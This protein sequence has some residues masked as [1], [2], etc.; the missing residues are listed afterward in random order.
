MAIISSSLVVGH[1]QADGRRYV[2]ETHID[3]LGIEHRFEYGPVGAEVDCDAVM[4]ARVVELAETLRAAEFA[5]IEAELLAGRN[6]FPADAADFGWCTRLEALQYVF[7]SLLPRPA[8][9]VAHLAPLVA[10]VSDEELAANG[11][12][13]EQI[14]ALRA[15]AA[16]LIELLPAI[17]APAFA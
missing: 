12:S 10:A 4:A 8:R 7:A 11:F 5:H 9:E 3:H 2:T 17:T 1:A 16:E 15:R 13:S 6:P 14:S